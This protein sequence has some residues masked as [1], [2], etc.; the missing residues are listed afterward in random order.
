MA[1]PIP[2]MDLKEGLA[3]PG[4]T[5]EDRN[6]CRQVVHPTRFQLTLLVQLRPLPIGRGARVVAVT[7][8]SKTD[9]I[10]ALGADVVLTRDDDI[11]ATLGSESID[12][13]ID[14]VAGPGFPTLLKVLKRGGRY[15][16]SGAIALGRRGLGLQGRSLR[17][18]DSQAAA[19]A[20]R[21]R[22]RPQRPDRT[23]PHRPE[24]APHLRR[25]APSPGR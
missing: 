8:P 15:V 9:A 24:R 20:G 21:P 1:V 12:V 7:S 6:L 16:S 3:I 4:K 11:L 23:G 14:N 19:A 5:L 18:E 13:A 22:P 10:R 2:T 17:L 25:R